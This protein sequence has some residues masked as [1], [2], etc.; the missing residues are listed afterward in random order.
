L[1]PPLAAFLSPLAPA[2]SAPAIAASGAPLRP[3]VRALGVLAAGLVV[4]VIGA[5]A[6]WRAEGV[7]PPAPSRRSAPSP[8]AV[9]PLIEPLP[10]RPRPPSRTT[11]AAGTQPTIDRRPVATKIR[12]WAKRTKEVKRASVRPHPRARP[13]RARRR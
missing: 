10:E 8:G 11:I 6:L 13:G 2:A 12:R 9:T 1:P 3:R 5:T 7:A 4:A